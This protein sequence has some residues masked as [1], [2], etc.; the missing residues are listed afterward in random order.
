MVIL[1]L[2]EYHWLNSVQPQF[3]PEPCKHPLLASAFLNEPK[4]RTIIEYFFNL[5]DVNMMLKREFINYLVKPN[6]VFNLQ[7][8][9]IQPP[10]LLLRALASL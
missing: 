5:A 7:E 3:F 6:K 2:Y 8:S 1:L 10:A 9:L 4:F